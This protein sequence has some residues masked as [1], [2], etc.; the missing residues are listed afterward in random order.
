MRPRA[1]P[2]VGGSVAVAYLGARVP[3]VVRKVEDDGRTLVVLTEDGQTL[4]FA[5]SRATGWFTVR[6]QQS[7]ERLLFE[8]DPEHP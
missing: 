1:I 2:R 7:A 6:G 8:D 3:G 4:T 5:L